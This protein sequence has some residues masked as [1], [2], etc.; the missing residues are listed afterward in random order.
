MW[1]IVPLAILLLLVLLISI[2]AHRYARFPGDL[3]LELRLQALHSDFVKQTM[4][5]VSEL[6]REPI[7][8]ALVIAMA[9]LFWLKHRR[10]ASLLVIVA[11]LLSLA[12][13]E[14]KLLVDRPRPPSDLVLVLETV[15]T[16]SFPSAHSIFAMAF[17]GV[18]VYFAG[19][20]ITGPILKR[21]AQVGAAV[22]ILLIGVSR[23]YL[24]VHW[25]SDV[26]GGYL[27][28]GLILAFVVMLNR[29]VSSVAERS[30]R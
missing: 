30:E 14:L 22:F 3:T 25:P 21:A 7:A 8:T 17:F 15:S 16:S 29:W 11:G 20:Y 13:G 24:G 5:M 9:F 1:Q 27:V 2:C 18:L 23:V 26:V 6:G 28:G 10:N 4:R 12:G 19:I